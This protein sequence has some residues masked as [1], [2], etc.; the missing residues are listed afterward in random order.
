M[1]QFGVQGPEIGA[2]QEGLEAPDRRLRRALRSMRVSE[3]LSVCF[4]CLLVVDWYSGFCSFYFF[5]FFCFYFFYFE[6]SFGVVLRFWS[7]GGLVRVRV[8]CVVFEVLVECF[9]G[10]LL[11]LDVVMDLLHSRLGLTEC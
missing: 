1:L 7:S 3:P 9:W 4:S 2:A 11:N 10:F 8:W 5:V 6:V